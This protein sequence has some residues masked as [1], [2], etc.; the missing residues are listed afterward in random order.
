MYKKPRVVALGGDKRPVI[1]RIAR[2]DE[3]DFTRDS[4]VVLLVAANAAYALVQSNIHAFKPLVLH[5][6][7]V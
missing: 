3:A 2:D 4:P 5:L 1:L 7:R 6:Y